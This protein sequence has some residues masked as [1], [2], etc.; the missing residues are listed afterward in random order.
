M[1]WLGVVIFRMVVSLLTVTGAVQRGCM[2]MMVSLWWLVACRHKTSSWRT[3]V[4]V[5]V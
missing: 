1:W 5:I 3:R 2:V 4:C